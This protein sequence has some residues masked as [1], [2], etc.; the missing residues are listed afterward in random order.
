MRK[1]SWSPVGY[2]LVSATFFGISTPLSK[3]LIGEISP[4]FLVSFLYLGTA[5]G[6]TILGKILKSGTSPL[7]GE[8]RVRAHD[9]PWLVL[10]ILAGGVIA[11]ILLM[12]SLIITPAATASLLL[13]FEGV[14]TLFIAFIVFQE[15][16][17]R[18]IWIAFGIITFASIL[19]TWN[20]YPAFGLS[21][22]AAGILLACVFWGIDNNATRNISGKDPVTVVALKGFFA[23]ITAM[24]LAIL[25]HAPIP[26]IS[27]SI[28]AMIL[29]FLCYGVSMVL[30]IRALRE[31]GAARTGAY[32]STLHLSGQYY[33]F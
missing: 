3:V 33:H 16:V 24:I 22:G 29:G 23:G 6:M 27:I 25:G 5:L 18:R 11:P 26:G 7:Q 32:Y 17:G 20:P 9:I 8:A 10:A 15:S 1:I 2:A 28:T 30:F 12:S 14:T 21:V 19:L 4:V 31:L 13:N